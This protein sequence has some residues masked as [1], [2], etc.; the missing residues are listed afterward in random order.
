MNWDLLDFVV[1]A[2]LLAAFGGAYALALRVSK[3]AA[4]RAGA[5]VA[6]AAGLA[7]VWINGAV[8]IIGD[9]NNDANM[10]YL[11]VLATGIIG[12]LATRFQAH[13]MSRAMV[14]TAAA[15]ILVPIIALVV[16]AGGNGPAWPWDAIV[17][18]AFFAALWLLSAWLFRRSETS[19]APRR[20][21]SPA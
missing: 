4:Y 5:T 20:D 16:G 11:G 6:L 15:Q 14:A 7:L 1:A 3:N 2:A 9:E 12:A 17:L 13:G 21:G 18:T 8:G 10:L 19:G